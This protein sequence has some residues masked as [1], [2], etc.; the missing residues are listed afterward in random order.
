MGYIWGKKPSQQCK[1]LQFADDV[2]IVAHDTK[3]FD[4]FIHSI[5]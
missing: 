2:A 4:Q 3:R 1:W 5:V